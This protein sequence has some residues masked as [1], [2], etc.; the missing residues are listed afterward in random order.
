MPAMVDVNDA[1]FR[2]VCAVERDD[3]AD[4]TDDWSESIWLVDAPFA[5][6]LAKRSLAA[7]N[8]AWAAFTCSVKA[9]VSMVAKS[10]RR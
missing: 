9:V 5:S 6:S 4:V 8:C 7:V 2:F 3:S 10:V 1:S